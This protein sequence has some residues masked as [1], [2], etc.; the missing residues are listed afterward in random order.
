MGGTL[1][2]QMCMRNPPPDGMMSS[3]VRYGKGMVLFDMVI[4][5]APFASDRDRHGLES[6][7]E[8]AE[9]VIQ[10]EGRW[11]SG[12]DSYKVYTCNDADDSAVIS[13]TLTA[14]GKRLQ[15]QPSQA[16]RWRNT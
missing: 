10:R 14:A 13:R 9:R 5:V 7:G 8:I 2:E 11:K 16:T 15:T 4:C 1:T 6:R 3:V 12:T